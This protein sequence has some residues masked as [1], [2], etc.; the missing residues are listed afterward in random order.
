[1]PPGPCAEAGAYRHLSIRMGESLWR[2]VDTI[3]SATCAVVQLESM[4]SL[5]AIKISKFRT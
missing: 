3:C 2:A 4:K 1:V 5:D